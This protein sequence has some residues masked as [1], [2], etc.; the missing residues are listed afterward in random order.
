MAKIISIMQDGLEKF[1]HQNRTAFDKAVPSPNI[2]ANL[3]KQL[4]QSEQIAPTLNKNMPLSILKPS[5]T[6]K[7][8]QLWRYASV[9]AV[10]LLLLSIG[11]AVG[12]YWAS[13]GAISTQNEIAL[14]DISEEYA[15]V[16]AF[17]TRQISNSMKELKKYNY[18]KTLLD[19]LEELDAAFHDLKREMGHSTVLTDQEIIQAMVENYQM[20]IEILERV[21]ERLPR[22]KTAKREQQQ[23]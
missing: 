12:S 16:E 22:N 9:A 4:E 19:D 18:D 15:E 6:N 8:K 3:E 10:G 1:V 14:G 7:R 11:G 2:W 13:N 5:K 20:K 17:Y 21:L 23:L